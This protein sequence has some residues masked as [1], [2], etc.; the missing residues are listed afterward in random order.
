MT[1]LQFNHELAIRSY[2][3]LDFRH[4]DGRSGVDAGDS[5]F[6]GNVIGKQ[7]TGGVNRAD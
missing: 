1:W 6:G 4:E 3:F 2:L 7:L 5:V